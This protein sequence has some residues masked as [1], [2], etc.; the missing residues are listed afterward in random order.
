P[1]LKKRSI[2]D[3][4]S[5]AVDRNTE[6]LKE[7]ISRRPASEPVDSIYD[8]PRL[9]QKP[10]FG[11]NNVA[12]AASMESLYETMTLKTTEETNPADD[13]EVEVINSTMLRSITEIYAK[14]TQSSPLAI[15]EEA[16]AEYGY[17]SE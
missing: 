4:P 9:Y 6:E 17:V 1:L 2:S 12:R 7:D 10:K 8:Y 16:P 11:G 5:N 3:P 14:F 13:H 15:S